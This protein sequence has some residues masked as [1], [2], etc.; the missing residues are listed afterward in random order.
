[1]GGLNNP[2]TEHMTLQSL[3]KQLIVTFPLPCRMPRDITSIVP[4][5]NALA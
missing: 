5:E 1:M 4:R 2:N 3:H